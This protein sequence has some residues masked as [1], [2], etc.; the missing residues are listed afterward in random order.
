MRARD[1]SSCH[2]AAY[3]SLRRHFE[4]EEDT[5]AARVALREDIE[6]LRDG[7]RVCAQFGTPLVATGKSCDSLSLNRVDSSRKDYFSDNVQVRLP[8]CYTPSPPSLPPPL[9]ST[10]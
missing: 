5:P 9:T 4:T 3:L 2:S 10:H 7:A 8:P 6:A 1:C